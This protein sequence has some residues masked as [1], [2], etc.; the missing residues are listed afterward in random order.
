[1]YPFSGIEMSEQNLKAYFKSMDADHNHALDYE[2]FKQAL[3]NV[4]PDN[5][6]VRKLFTCLPQ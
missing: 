1:L 4:Q 2:E 6:G 3:M 5:V